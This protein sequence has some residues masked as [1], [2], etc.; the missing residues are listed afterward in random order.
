M[1]LLE[2]RALSQPSMLQHA[3]DDLNLWTQRNHMLLNGGKCLTKRQSDQLER[4]QKRACRTIMGKD[5]CGYSHALQHLGLTALASRREQLTLKFARSLLGSEFRDWLPP[6]RAQIT[7]R[8][9]RNNHKLNC[10]KARTKRYLN[11]C[12]PYMTRLVNQHGQ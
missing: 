9:T 10:P 12:V 5:Y 11:S 1:N 3:L 6:P 2:T 4:L 7:G 8:V